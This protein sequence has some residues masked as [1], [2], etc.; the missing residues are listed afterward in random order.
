EIPYWVDKAIQKSVSINPEQRFQVLSEF[1]YALNNLGSKHSQQEHIPLIQANP[2]RFWK[3]LSIILLL[4]N[5]VLLY[6][7]LS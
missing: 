5:L 3:G 6:F 1:I 2:V 7:V 4:I